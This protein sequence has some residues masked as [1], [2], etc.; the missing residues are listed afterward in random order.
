MEYIDLEPKWE[1][2]CR[3]FS[4]FDPIILELMGACRTADIVRQTQK[5]GAKSV[6]FIFCEDGTVDTQIETA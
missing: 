6:S 2:L 5:N 1:E 3:A 4:R